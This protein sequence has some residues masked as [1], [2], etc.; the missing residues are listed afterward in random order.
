MQSTRKGVAADF[1]DLIFWVIS[2]LASP[3]MLLVSASV[4]MGEELQGLSVGEETE[5]SAAEGN[6]LK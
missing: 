1:V 5:A 3:A 4:P 2:F 6:E